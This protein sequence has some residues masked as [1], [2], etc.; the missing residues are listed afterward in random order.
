MKKLTLLLLVLYI[1]FLNL[2]VFEM[3]YEQLMNLLAPEAHNIASSDPVE[4]D[5]ANE[6]GAGVEEE[7]PAAAPE[8][9]PQVVRIHERRPAIRFQGV[10]RMDGVLFALI[11]EETY[12]SGDFVGDYR[13]VAVRPQF[14]EIQGRTRRFRYNLP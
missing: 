1:T 4:T 3:Y 7:K 11:N 5:A 2:N 9:E 6:E 12:R 14:I 8:P 10:M 13:L